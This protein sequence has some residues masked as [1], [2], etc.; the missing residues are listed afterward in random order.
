M[1]NQHHR[2]GSGNLIY[3][4]H[5]KHRPQQR[6]QYRAQTL[7]PLSLSAPFNPLQDDQQNGKG[8]QNLIL[9]HN[10]I[11]P[12]KIFFPVPRMRKAFQQTE[13]KQRRRH[14]AQHGKP[15]RHLSRKLKKIVYMVKYHQYQ[16]QPLQLKIRKTLPLRSFFH[17]TCL[18]N[19][20]NVNS[21]SYIPLIFSIQR[22]AGNSK[23]FIRKNTLLYNFPPGYLLSSFLSSVF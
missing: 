18:L 17:H 11:N 12:Q 23:D 6:Q 7:Q 4:P 1:Q 8:S 20:G 14:P 3:K 16:C 9:R 21:P 19:P 10:G 15:F 13:Q 22:I 2:R 5:S